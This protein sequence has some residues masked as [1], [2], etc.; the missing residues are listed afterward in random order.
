MADKSTIFR[1]YTEGTDSYKDWNP[2]TA[3]PY[4]KEARKTIADPDGASAT[5]E[6]TSIPSPFARIDLVKSAFQQVCTKDK[7][8]KIDLD[9]DTIF[10][11]MVSDSLDVAEIFFNIDRYKG[12]IEIIKWDAKDDLQALTD[13]DQPGCQYLGDALYKYMK[14][15]DEGYNFGKLQNIYLLNY[16]NGPEGEMNIIGATS[17][18]TLFFSN[19]NDLTYIKDIFFA[20]ND[21]PFDAEY[22]PLYKRDFEFVKYL[23]ALRAGIAGFASLFPEVN[24]YL[25]L[26]HSKIAD[27][28]KKDIL[29]NVA[30]TDLEAL[31]PIAIVEGQSTYSAE[32]LGY[33]LYQKATKADIDEC[34]FVIKA[35]KTTEEGL[36]PLVLPTDTGN[37][38]TGLRYTSGNWTKE[39]HAPYFD[40]E[41]I[42][43]RILPQEGSQYPYLTIG[44]FIEDQIINVTKYSLNSECYFDGN[45]HSKD[46]STFLL[47]VKPLFFKYFT[48]DDLKGKMSDGKPMIEMETLASGLGIKVTLRIPILGNNR[49]RYIEYTR[50]YYKN[51]AV[52]IANNEGAVTSLRFAGFVM[53]LVRFTNPDDAIYNATCLQFKSRENEFIF[54]NADGDPVEQQDWKC[55]N[56]QSSDLKADN[57][58]VKGENFDFIRVSNSAHQCNGIILPIFKQQSSIEEY[59]FAVDLGTSNTHIEFRKQGERASSPLAFDKNDRP[60]HPIFTPGTTNKTENERFE[61]DYIPSEVG[62]GDFHFPTRTV[63]SSANTTNWDLVVDPYM[64]VNIPLYFG[65]REDYPHNKDITDIKWGKEDE[66]RKMEAYI[67]C[68][69]LMLR[70]KVLLNDGNLQ[71]TKITWFYPISMAPRRLNR[72]KTIWDKAYTEYFGTTGATNSIS[73]SSAPIQYFFSADARATDLVNVDIGGGTTDIAFAKN[74]EIISVTSFRFAGNTLF[75]DSLADNPDNGIIDTFKPQILKVLQDNTRDSN[76]IAEL[77]GVFR[78]M[79]DR[80]PSDM[81]AFLF[82]L[83]DNTIIKEAGISPDQID[84]NHILQED[85]KF[86]IVFII[87]YTAIVYHIAQIIKAQ[88]LDLPRH[89]SFSGN[90]SKIL[91]A[92]TPNAKHLALYT[93]KVFEQILD[94][95]YDKELDIIGLDDNSNS[96]ESTCKG[97]IIAKGDSDDRSK[98]IVMRSDNTGL[99]RE[100]YAEIKADKEYLNRAEESVKQFF[101]FVLNVMPKRFDFDGYFGVDSSSIKIAKEVSQKDIDTFMNKGIEHMLEETEEDRPVKETF[102]FYPIKGVLQSISEEI[103]NSL[104]AQ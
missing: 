97:G 9:G 64:L 79:E 78:K 48:A 73:E 13:S 20:D 22:Q 59:E 4:N 27:T 104:K 45:L 7:T 81:A 28:T 47:P 96:K 101:D 90:G 83:R 53:P 80:N 61:K 30:P 98:I 29:R 103:H 65:K 12:K 51:K 68:I 91:R 57:Y 86:K 54:C 99:A 5:H 82:S 34:Q 85:D 84:L 55:R 69:M 33:A 66:Q 19:A 6:I 75:E 2:G 8:G 67:R 74:K 56:E 11:K 36:P 17:P 95:E 52:D 60:L 87:F 1:L 10:H 15:D 62:T 35:S 26:T 37:Q 92:I 89:I 70:N 88:G 102:F 41:D 44:D 23:F 63:L 14:S 18:A 72:M 77:V 46:K 76:R 43:Q 3:F 58:L 38:Y 49:V 100:T 39:N 50:K 71:K 94:H 93:K 16:V 40:A 24:D 42:D 21:K 25:E 31:S 32:V